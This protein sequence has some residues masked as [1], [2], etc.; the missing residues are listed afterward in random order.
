MIISYNMQNL[1]AIRTSLHV[2]V[3]VGVQKWNA[4]WPGKILPSKFPGKIR[5]ITRIY[6]VVIPGYISEIIP[7]I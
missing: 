7:K 4:Q 6:P 1:V 5:V 2:H 3:Y